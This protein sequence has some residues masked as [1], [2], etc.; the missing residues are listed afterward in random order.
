MFLSCCYINAGLSAQGG[1]SFTTILKRL[2]L[3][4]DEQYVGGGL[5][6]S[7]Y[8]CFCHRHGRHSYDR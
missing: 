7:L 4:F 2:P 5:N 6:E 8:F 3:F 1:N